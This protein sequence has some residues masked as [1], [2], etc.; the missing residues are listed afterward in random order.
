MNTITKEWLQN[1]ITGIESIIDDKSFVCSEIAFEIGQVNNILTAFKIALASLAAVSDER[2]AYELFMEKRFGESVDRRRAKNGDRE[3]MAWDMAL[4]WII[5]C[6][7]AAML[8]G[9]QPVNQ[10]YNLPQT[11][12]EQV[13]DLY[14]MQ[15]EDGRTCTFHTDA[16]KAVQWLQACDGN[17]VQE[18]VKLERLQNALAGNY[19]VTPDGWISC[20]DRMPEKGQN[21]LISVNFDSSL[22]EPLICSARYTGSTFRR[23]DATIKPGNG[24]EQATHWMP[25]P[26]PPQ[27][28]K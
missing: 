24:I 20:S 18:Y 28:V 14:E 4:G 7:R 17:R 8:Q 6:H 27:E 25:L 1:T 16:Q 12:F 26:E 13:A 3:Y 19:P 22:V 10:T 15:F 21:V 23:G 5:W 11:H 9:G 2:A